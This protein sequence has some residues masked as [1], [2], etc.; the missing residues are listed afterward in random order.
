MLPHDTISLW[1]YRKFIPTPQKSGWCA[2][3]GKKVSVFQWKKIIY[4][5]VKTG[6]QQ[7]RKPL[8]N[9]LSNFDAF[10]RRSCFNLRPEQQNVAEFIAPEQKIEADGI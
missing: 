9:S 8:R 2:C 7:R 3:V 6:L 4:T 1:Q 10:T 5:V